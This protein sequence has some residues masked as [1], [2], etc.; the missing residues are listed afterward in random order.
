MLRVRGLF[1]NESE[2]VACLSGLK[3][4]VLV[5]SDIINSLWLLDLTPLYFFVNPAV[6]LYTLNGGYMVTPFREN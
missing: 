5:P 6:S 3:C 2:N 4:I 1:G